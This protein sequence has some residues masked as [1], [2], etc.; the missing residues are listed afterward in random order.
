VKLLL[1]VFGE[2]LRLVE[3]KIDTLH[4]MK[5]E[6]TK[7]LGVLQSCGQ[8]GREV[9]LEAFSCNGCAELG[10]EKNVPDTLWVLLH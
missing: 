2:K 8:C 6:L 4:V 7:T 3:A 1:R 9:L 5:N 10:P